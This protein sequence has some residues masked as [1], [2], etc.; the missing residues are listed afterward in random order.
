MNINPD[1]YKVQ[2]AISTNS[3]IRIGAVLEPNFEAA[4][5]ELVAPFVERNMGTRTVVWF[6][7]EESIRAGRTFEV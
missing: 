1:Y 5:P 7:A 2:G 3:F 4:A 6:F